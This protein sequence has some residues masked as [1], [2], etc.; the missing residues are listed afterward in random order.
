MVQ[1]ISEP[2][3]RRIYQW[4]ETDTES[5]MSLKWKYFTPQR[6]RYLHPLATTDRPVCQ[7]TGFYL[8]LRDL[9][10]KRNIHKLKTCK[11]TNKWTAERKYGMTKGA[12]AVLSSSPRSWLIYTLRSVSAFCW[13]RPNSLKKWSLYM[14][15]SLAPEGLFE[16]PNKGEITRAQAPIYKYKISRDQIFSHQLIILLILTK[17]YLNYVLIMLRES[18]L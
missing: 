17:F 5:E 11:Y 13:S 10:I 18:W 12:F 14:L 15:R 7:Q 3:I 8:L 16:I 1:Y 4:S 9:E 6:G 2:A